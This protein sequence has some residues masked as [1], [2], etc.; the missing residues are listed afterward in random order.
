[1]VTCKAELETIAQ[2]MQKRDD[3]PLP[4]PAPVDF[5]TDH[6]RTQV[7]LTAP[8]LE[9]ETLEKLMAHHMDVTGAHTVQIQV[10]KKR[11]VVWIN[12]NGVN[13]LRICRIA[14]LEMEAQK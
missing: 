2:S 13:L 3:G 5:N 11:D 12:V 14:N 10:S 9:M 6:W 7:S 8:D 4:P 1:M